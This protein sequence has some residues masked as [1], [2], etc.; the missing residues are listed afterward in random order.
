MAFVLHGS[1]CSLPHGHSH[2]SKS[3]SSANHNHSHNNGH[4]H[5]GHVP[6]DG[7]N[8]LSPEMNGRNYTSLNNQNSSRAHSRHNSFTNKLGNPRSQDES[9]HSVDILRTR[10]DD[11][12]IHRMSIDGGLTRYG[13]VMILFIV[14][15]KN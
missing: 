5:N 14:V 7:H 13:S 8:F 2:G 10:G 11:P 12:I 9:R 4:T 15:T 6:K 1:C 3:C